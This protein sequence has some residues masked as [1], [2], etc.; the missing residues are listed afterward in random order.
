[1]QR[2]GEI[3]AAGENRNATFSDIE[4]PHRKLPLDVL[5]ASAPETRAHWTSLTAAQAAYA[6][7]YLNETGN[8]ND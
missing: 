4:K 3:V 1:L 8:A 7:R 5:A 6:N 2:T